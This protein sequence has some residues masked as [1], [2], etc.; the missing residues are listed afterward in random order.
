MNHLVQEKSSIIPKSAI[1]ADATTGVIP[2]ANN[3]VEPNRFSPPMA[4][5]TALF[6]GEL[7]STP[8]CSNTCSYT[9]TMMAPRVLAEGRAKVNP[10][11]AASIWT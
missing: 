3:A 10:A 8:Q 11:N 4:I 7:F 9:W 5:M 2:P 1:K 6:N